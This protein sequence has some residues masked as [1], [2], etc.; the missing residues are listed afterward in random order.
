VLDDSKQHNRLRLEVGMGKVKD[1]AS[2]LQRMPWVT[3]IEVD[4]SSDRYRTADGGRFPMKLLFRRRTQA[5]PWGVVFAGGRIV[6]SATGNTGSSIKVGIMDS[7]IDCD[8]SDLSSAVYGGFDFDFD[9]QTGC[10]VDTPHGTAV[11]GIVAAADN[12]A[13]VIGMAPGVHLYGYRI[14][15][16]GFL[17]STTVLAQA[18][19][20]A[21]AAGVKVINYSLANCGTAPPSAVQTAV[22]DAIAAGVIIVAA[23]GNGVDGGCSNSDPI[24][25]VAALSGVIAVSAFDDTLHVYDPHGQYGSGVVLSG[26]EYVQ[27]DSGG[28]GDPIWPR[29]SGTSA[30]TPHV[31][32]AMALALA[33][34]YTAS[35]AISR[36]E[37]VVRLGPGQ[38]GRDSHYGYG[39]VDAA[40]LLDAPVL[41]SLTWCTDG[42]ITD[43]S[44]LA[45]G[46]LCSFTLHTRHGAPPLQSRLKVITSV[47]HDTTIYDWGSITRNISIPPNV[48]GAPADTAG[49]TMTVIGWVRDNPFHRLSDSVY[50]SFFVC[51]I[52]AGDNLRLAPRGG[53]IRP[54]NAGGCGE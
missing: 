10:S 39:Q 30:A 46:R 52:T 48:G 51:N 25:G 54:L 14:T 47:V 2:A 32:G 53:S 17:L 7:G 20:S 38:S 21:V 3:G 12:S 29:F 37:T 34:G 33:A 24:S 4:T 44:Q 35:G 45:A 42:N 27:T 11:A 15:S 18:I 1:V 16:G 13:G 6:D 50:V 26:P 49:Y 23:A 36:L 31:T 5:V 22:S 9:S 41:D 40:G 28:F 19:D 8:G 43:D